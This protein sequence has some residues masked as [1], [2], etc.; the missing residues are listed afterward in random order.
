MSYKEPVG[1]V[2]CV[3]DGKLRKRLYG[4]YSNNVA[5]LNYYGF[6]IILW[7]DKE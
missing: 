5:V 3:G 1:V 6:I 7:R 4:I 2:I